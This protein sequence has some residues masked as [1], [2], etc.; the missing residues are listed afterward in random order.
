MKPSSLLCTALTGRIKKFHRSVLSLVLFSGI[1]INSFAHHV[2]TFTFGCVT[3]GQNMQI[4]AI[5]VAAPADTWYQWQFLDNSGVWQ[6]F[7]NGSNTINGVSFIASGA[8]A[9]NVANDAPLLTI[10]SVNSALENV[11]VRV[12][13]RSGGPPC[14][15]PP[16]TTYGDDDPETKYL[17]LHV[18]AISTICPPDSYLCEGN[19]LSNLLGY[20]GGFESKTYDVGTAT[21]TST[22]FGAGIAS[23]DYTFG[24]VPGSYADVNN[25]Y[26]IFFDFATKLAPH[27]GNFQL[28]VRGSANTTDRAWYKSV[29]VTAGTTYA[30]TL[31]AARVD[32]TDPLINLTVNGL[33]VQSYDLSLQ[34][35]GNWW[36]IAGQYTATSTG[37][38]IISV[39]D[40]RA[41]GLNNYTIDDICFRVCLNCSP[42]PLHNLELRAALQGNTVDLK[43]TTENE[44]NT[45]TFV[46]ER[47][48]DGSNYNE[49]GLKAAAG[50]TSSV[51]QYQTTDDIQALLSSNVVYYRIKAVDIDGRFTYSNVATVRLSKKAGVQVWPSPFGDDINITYNANANTKIEV[52]IVNSIGKVVRQSNYSVSRGL[53][54]VSVN[55]LGSLSSGVYFIRITDKNS[56]E[57]YM[58]KL[59][60]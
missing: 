53:N 29:A 9:A 33:T 26:A 18:F 56:N 14:N 24:D 42:L 48:T 5:V 28:V 37:N 45:S 2:E 58:Q 35:V 39:G 11:I 19:Q 1:A 43:W 25:P 36:R 21:Y 27:T 40:G 10:N 4:D 55:N 52:S 3:P 8:T 60:K 20:Y 47:S 23:S 31:F 41:G 30:F 34:P 38:I 7:I 17:R 44:V 57:V 49:A 32:G 16:G 59:V 12:L 46:I 6:C 50:Q 51:T 54:Q 13:M 15:A 22:N